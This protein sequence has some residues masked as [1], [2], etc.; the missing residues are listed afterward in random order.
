MLSILLVILLAV[1][2]GAFVGGYFLG[3]DRGKKESTTDSTQSYQHRGVYTKNTGIC[4]VYV[5]DRNILSFAAYTINY[6]GN[7]HVIPAFRGS[8]P[9]QKFIQPRAVLIDQQLVTVPGNP[10]LTP[11]G[12]SQIFIYQ[13]RIG[14]R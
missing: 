1:F 6:D 4:V 8:L 10:L 12:T 2:G 7:S 3:K 5:F 13:V 14:S 9:V 11:K